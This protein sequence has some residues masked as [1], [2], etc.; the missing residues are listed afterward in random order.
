[1]FVRAMRTCMGE[2]GLATRMA[3]VEASTLKLPF[4]QLTTLVT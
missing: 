3:G 1:M 2:L 4:D